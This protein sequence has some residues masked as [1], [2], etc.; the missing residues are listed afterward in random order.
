MIKAVLRYTD[1]LQDGRKVYSVLTNNKIPIV[2]TK[3]GWSMYP[4]ITVLLKDYDQLNNV[5]YALNHTCTYEV[6][7][8][9]YHTVKEK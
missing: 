1:C 9:K 2:G 4:R 6:R 8:I 7:L 3:Q 5:L